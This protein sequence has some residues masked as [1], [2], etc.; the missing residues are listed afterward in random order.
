MPFYDWGSNVCDVIR[1]SSVGCHLS[2]NHGGVSGSSTITAGVAQQETKRQH[3]RR[4]YCPSIATET[5]FHKWLV[6][7]MGGV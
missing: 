3:G 2:D 4:A 5:R 6:L 1:W 7:F